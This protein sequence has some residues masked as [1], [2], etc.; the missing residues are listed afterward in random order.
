V[1]A[2]LIVAPAARAATDFA[3]DIQPLFEKHCYECH[4][5]KKQRNGFRLDRRSRAMA[6]VVRRNI[7]PG[8][9]ASS[10]LYRRILDASMGTQM[11]PDDALSDQQIETVR[12]WIDEG[13]PW[14]DQLANEVDAP[15]ADAAALALIDR[16]R[17]AGKDGTAR[18]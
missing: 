15:P 16:I 4:G 7:V 6:G 1:C 8:S 14:P 9:S 17:A 18:R 10:R 2:A 11:P 3:R 5:P 12:H 13:A